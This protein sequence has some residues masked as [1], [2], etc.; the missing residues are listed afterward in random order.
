[1]LGIVTDR[2]QALPIGASKANE[3]NFSIF[4]EGVGKSDGSQRINKVSPKW[5]RFTKLL[6]KSDQ[7]YLKVSD[8]LQCVVVIGWYLIKICYAPKWTSF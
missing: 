1:M 4:L 8:S 6:N 3:G 5:A 2:Q 7:K